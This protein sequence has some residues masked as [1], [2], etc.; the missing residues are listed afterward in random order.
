M[1]SGCQ[2]SV[3]SFCGDGPFSPRVQRTRILA[4]ALEE[5][6]GFD[7]ERVPDDRDGEAAFALPFRAVHR[8][9]RPMFID[10][11]EPLAAWRLPHWTPR[12]CGALLIGYP[13]SPLYH[14]ARRL[15]RR[16]IP[17]V[18]DVGDPWALTAKETT[19]WRVGDWRA[20]AAESFL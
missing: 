5:R 8:I 14:S 3:V 17:Y 2:V 11:Y 4:S 20:R 15:A 13:F 16:G 19:R 9:T 18:V 6:F 7:V 12:G 10:R 1:R